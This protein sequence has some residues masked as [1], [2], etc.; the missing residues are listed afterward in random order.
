MKFQLSLFAVLLLISIAAFSQRTIKGRVV[1]AVTGEALP[2]SSVFINSTSI[3][4]VADRNGSFELNNIPSGR[5]DLVVSL[6][7]YETNVF[8]FTSDQLP[9]NLKIEMNVKVKELE[10]VTVEPSVEET[11]E[12]WGELFLESFIGK[13]PNAKDCKIK[14]TEVIR[15]RFYRKSNRVAAY[16]DE[17]L[18]IENRSLGY[19][20]T[21][22]LEQFEVSF[23]ENTVVFAGYPFFE[24]IEKSRRGLQRRWKEA[25][26][27]A[28]NG[29]MM[30]FLRYLYKDSLEQAGYEIRKMKRI[31]NL[32][33]ERVREIYRAGMIIND[34]AG[35]KIVTSRQFPPDSS[36]YYQQIMRQKDY[37]EEI[38]QALKTSDSLIIQTEGEYK[39]LY[40]TDYL[41][42][43][44]KKELEDKEYLLF[45][46][47]NRKPMFQQSCIWLVSGTPVAIGING[48][49]YPPEEVFSMSYWGWSEKMANNLPAD[50]QPGD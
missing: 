6:V 7:G 42:I 24:E 3:G 25:R 5:Q 9:L 34:S 27:K 15:F 17:P 50:Y 38:G 37:T 18:I 40:F 14:N 10:N 47:E 1:N 12:K 19:K 48:N 11:W 28:F 35:R 29:S 41:Y 22:Q 21:Y 45:Y 13:V 16:S 43:T 23:K 26:E 49:Y 39:Y 8:N 2:G 36:A 46:R 20:I 4:T 44:Y 31:P 30:H 32:E 33:K